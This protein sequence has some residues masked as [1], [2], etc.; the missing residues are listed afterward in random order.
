MSL[1]AEADERKD[2][3]VV[4]DTDDAQDPQM[5]AEVLDVPEIN[6]VSCKRRRERL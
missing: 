4:R 3:D 1:L 2:G 5:D 6:H